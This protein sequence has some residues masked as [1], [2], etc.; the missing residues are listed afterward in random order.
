M[1]VRVMTE[2]ELVK[3]KIDFEDEGDIVEGFVIDIRDLDAKHVFD[4]LVFFKLK[5]TNYW[6]LI[7]NADF[8]AADMAA[9]IR[10]I[11]IEAIGVVPRS[12]EFKEA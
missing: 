5:D 4:E 6:G 11:T 9:V 7:G 8:A 3:A 12:W 1:I 10:W 2:E